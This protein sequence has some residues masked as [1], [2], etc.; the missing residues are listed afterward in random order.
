MDG[1]DALGVDPC[2]AVLDF[3][4]FPFSAGIAEKAG[5]VDGIQFECALELFLDFG[6]AQGG[7]FLVGIAV[8][9]QFLQFR[10]GHAVVFKDRRL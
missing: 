6:I 8:Y 10:D 1:C 2:Q 5:L 9:Q 3:F 7:V 4:F